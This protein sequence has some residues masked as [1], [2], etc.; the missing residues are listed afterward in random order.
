M[1]MYLQPAFEE[2]RTEVLHAHMRAH[3]LATFIV[4]VSGEIVVNHMP[5][6]VDPSVGEHGAL[7]GHIPRDNPVRQSLDGR[8]AAVAVFQGANTYITPSWYPSKHAH[9][10]A[11]PT[12]NYAVVHAHGRPRLIDD[13]EW[14]LAHLEQLTAEHESKQALPWKVSDA[15]KEY[16]ERMIA[17]L[18]G[19]EMPITL[20]IGKWKVSQNRPHGD[21]LGVAA[22][23]ASQGDADSLA[24]AELVMQASVSSDGAD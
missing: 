24:M 10:K 20:L 1:T 7:R 11:V 8:L 19:I 3:P 17:R 6:Q 5:F 21:R 13:A 15:P 9:G 22:G 23:L 2:K 16:T 18:V 14:L 12:W 4:T